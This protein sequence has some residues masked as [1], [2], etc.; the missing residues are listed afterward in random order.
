M[1]QKHVQYYANLQRSYYVISKWISAFVDKSCLNY[2]LKNSYILFLVHST[3]LT[4]MQ[5]T[6]AQQCPK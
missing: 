6:F 3:I 5:A 4:R 2:N 1:E